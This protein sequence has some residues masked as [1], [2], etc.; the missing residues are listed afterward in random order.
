MDNNKLTA[1]ATILKFFKECMSKFLSLNPSS[2]R[3]HMYSIQ[4]LVDV[5]WKEDRFI[6]NGEYE[7][8]QTHNDHRKKYFEAQMKG[9]AMKK[10][11]RQNR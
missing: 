3:K 8:E 7:V 5:K 6:L 10:L 2:V 1:K 11:T 9:P 4:N